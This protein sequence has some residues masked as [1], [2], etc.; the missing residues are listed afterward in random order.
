M[1]NSSG[2]LWVGAGKR[3]GIVGRDFH[4]RV[5]CPLSDAAVDIVEG[6]FGMDWTTAWGSGLALRIINVLI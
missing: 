6:A 3:V 5:V 1:S 4:D 2:R